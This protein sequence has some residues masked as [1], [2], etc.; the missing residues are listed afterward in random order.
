MI[1]FA[2]TGEKINRYLSSESVNSVSSCGDGS[3][4]SNKNKKKTK[5]KLSGNNTSWIRSS[6]NRAFKKKSPKSIGRDVSSD[7]EHSVVDGETRIRSV[8]S[9]PLLSSKAIRSL[10]EEPEEL[11]DLRKQLR[12]KEMQLT[13]MRLESLTSAHQL[14]NLKEIVNQ[15]RMEMM[16]LKQDNDRLQRLANHKSLA[17]SQSSMTSAFGSHGSSTLPSTITST[18]P[19]PNEDSNSFE[20]V[21]MDTSP[22]QSS[23]TSGDFI[24]ASHKIIT[25]GSGSHLLATLNITTKTNWDQLDVLVKKCFKEHL[26]RVDS[27]LSLGITVDSLACYC[28]GAEKIQRNFFSMN[29]SNCQQSS[30]PELLPFGYLINENHINLQFKSPIDSLAFDTLTPKSVLNEFVTML[31]NNRRLIF[32]GPSG[33][34]KTFLAHR[35]AEYLS[36]KQSLN[37]LI[38]TSLSPNSSQEISLDNFDGD[39][40]CPTG[41]I[42]TFNIDH[43]NS[44]QLRAY[45][46][47]IIEQCQ[48]EIKSMT[49]RLPTVIILDNLHCC[50]DSLEEILTDL[51]RINSSKRFASNLILLN[52]DSN[53]I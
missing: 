45:L 40:R 5:I 44:K 52:S 47:N 24:N 31:A 49:N 27:S 39:N 32:T 30:L 11:R 1:S 3:N 17:S 25:L 22:L 38:T 7:I 4:Y 33:V 36:I 14:E 8:P 37:P 9:S 29:Q 23:T 41:S 21:E 20:S 53:L 15:M 16:N 19:A 6:F 48:I 42:A 2:I 18:M 13:D 43:K 28:V 35:I 51:H 34:G 50:L 46:T 10:S 12:E 26:I